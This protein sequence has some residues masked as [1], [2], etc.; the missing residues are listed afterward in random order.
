M[1][2]NDRN[3]KKSSAVGY[4]TF[5]RSVRASRPKNVIVRTVVIPVKWNIAVLN[6]DV[7][8]GGKGNTGD[9]DCDCTSVPL[10]ATFRLTAHRMQFPRFRPPPRTTA[11]ARSQFGVSNNGFTDKPCKNIG[12]HLKVQ[13]YTVCYRPSIIF[14]LPKFSIKTRDVDYSLKYRK[15]S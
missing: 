15:I 4:G 12:I 8:T 11:R 7:L 10:V 5:G 2:A 1:N 13:K 14:K 9:C 6:R 3:T